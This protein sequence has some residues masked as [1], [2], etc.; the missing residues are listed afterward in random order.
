M[1]TALKQVISTEEFQR[2]NKWSH[3]AAWLVAESG[4]TMD[5]QM[6]RGFFFLYK[7]KESKQQT[8]EPA[9]DH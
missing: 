8:Y 4:D 3:A 9:F 7:D 2:I 5:M 1:T 6:Q